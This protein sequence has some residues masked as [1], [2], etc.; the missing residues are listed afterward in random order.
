M[1]QESTAKLW[2]I[3]SSKPE[4]AGFVLIGGSALALHIDHRISEDLDFAW[5]YGRL[6][7]EALKKLIKTEPGLEFVLDQNEVALQEA[8]DA[9]IDLADHT[10]NYLTNGV[11]VTFFP[12]YEPEKKL[13]ARDA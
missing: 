12:S 3:L 11:R 7:R 5:P 13:L 8:E 4:L 2:Q 6:P 9:G 1:L 10:Q